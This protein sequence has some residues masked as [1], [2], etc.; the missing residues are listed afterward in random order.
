MNLLL[1][2]QSGLVEHTR[3]HTGEKPY[4]CDMCE[5]AFTQ[6][7]NLDT[8]M[9]LH[10]NE[11]PFQCVNCKQRFRQVGDLKRHREFQKCGFTQEDFYNSLDPNSKLKNV[12]PV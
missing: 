4:K 3:T 2:F 9:K 11:M 5:M 10:K 12:Q 1:V 7:G 8:H 6:K